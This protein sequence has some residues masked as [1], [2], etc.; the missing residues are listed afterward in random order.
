MGFVVAAALLLV[1]GFSLFVGV[2]AWS[3]VAGSHGPIHR[4]TRVDREFK[5]IVRQLQ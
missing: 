5:R 4:Q 1:V 3:I 2:T